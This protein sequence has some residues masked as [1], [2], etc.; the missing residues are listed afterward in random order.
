MNDVCARFDELRAEIAKAQRWLKQADESV[1][2]EQ[3]NE[4]FTEGSD[5]QSACDLRD[6]MEDH[7][8]GLEKELFEL[9]SDWHKQ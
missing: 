4:A 1:N 9:T 8:M 7:L 2:L 5:L 3:E 6:A